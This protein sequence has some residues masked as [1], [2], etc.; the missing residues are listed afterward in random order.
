MTSDFVQNGDRARVPLSSIPIS[1]GDIN[2]IGGEN[3]EKGRCP[4]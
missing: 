4:R 2:S 3:I 1:A